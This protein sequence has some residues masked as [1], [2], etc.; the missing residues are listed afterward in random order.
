MTRR[1]PRTRPTAAEAFAHF[2]TIRGSLEGKCLNI[3]LDSKG[4]Q[5]KHLPIRS[6]RRAMST[7]HISTSARA[8]SHHS[9]HSHGSW[10]STDSARTLVAEITSP[11][12]E[13]LKGHEPV[14][15]TVFEER[16]SENKLLQRKKSKSKWGALRAAVKTMVR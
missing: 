16:E 13:I 15:R 2:E 5:T 3:P 8:P 4:H 12:K 6:P 11:V 1:D 10:G 9:H 7:L 14:V